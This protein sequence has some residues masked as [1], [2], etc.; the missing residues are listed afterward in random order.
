MR[1]FF[2]LVL[3]LIAAL[4]A[5]PPAAAGGR[6]DTVFQYSTINALLNGLY[7]GDMSFS[8]L[9]RHGD[10]GIGTFNA[11][12]GEMLALD[13]GFFQ[14]RS[15]GSVHAVPGNAATPF[16]VVTFFEA[17]TRAA[18][19]AGL[20]LEEL[21]RV[22]DGLVASANQFQAVRIDGRFS[23]VKVRSVPAQV[24]PYPPLAQVVGKQSVFEFQDIEGTLAGFR[25]PA[26]VAGLN[27]PGWHFHFLDRE[28]KRGG[29]VLALT[30]GEG[31][32]GI[33]EMSAFAMV[34]PR[35]RDFAATDLTGERKAELYRVEKGR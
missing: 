21:L 20:G 33:D 15:D 35:T 29:H 23:S 16:S 28:R 17:D 27:V 24:P 13:G 19:P 14:I 12:D 9:A 6:E 1:P 3:V 22:L 32:I 30:T 18:L 34:L 8:E 31:K 26:F 5:P 11:L 2:L 10:F 7:D 25:T 4:L